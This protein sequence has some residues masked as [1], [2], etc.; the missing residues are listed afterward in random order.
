MVVNESA[1][2]IAQF[3]TDLGRVGLALQA[4]GIVV[5]LALIFQF[6]GFFLN[7]KRLAQI[8]EIRKDMVRIE[9]KID[10]VISDVGKRR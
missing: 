8:A 7:R 6:I 4:L 1:G 9:R 10:R 5:I 3:V 2:F